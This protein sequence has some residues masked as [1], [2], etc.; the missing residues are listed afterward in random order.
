VFAFGGAPFDGSGAGQTLAQPV[1]DMVA[2]SHG[3]YWLAEGLK[4]AA[5]ASPFSAGLVSALNAR[6]GI[7]TAAVLD[8]NSGQEYLYRPDQEGITASI[9]KVEILGT[10]LADAQ[11]QHR[12]LSPTEQALATAMIEASDDNAATS[13]WNEVGGAPAV[14]AFDAS[15]HMVDTTPNL[16]WGLTTT[17]AADQVTL[18]HELVVDHRVLSAGSADYELSLM[19]SVEPDQAWGVSAGVTGGAGV[20]LKN[21]WLPLNGIWTV[22][23]IGWIDGDGRD[24]LIAVLTDDD[25]GEGYGMA[26]IS[27][28]SQAAW[29]VLG[30]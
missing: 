26:S 25:P 18:L 23:S 1:V 2:N 14:A 24:Y 11:A 15:V 29:A 30:A 16:A 12:A 20:A 6:S 4:G 22:N 27:M 10:L 8:L 21:G 28:I 19:K 9:V 17:T 3:G 7:I 5:A 13:L